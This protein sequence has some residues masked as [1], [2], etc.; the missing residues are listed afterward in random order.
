MSRFC[1]EVEPRYNEGPT[2]DRPS[3][4]DA[5]AAASSVAKSRKEKDRRKAVFCSGVGF[6]MR[7]SLRVVNIR[8]RSR[9]WIRVLVRCWRYL[10][11][12][13]V[14]QKWPPVQGGPAQSYVP[15]HATKLIN[16]IDVELKPH[17]HNPLHLS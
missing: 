13:R 14:S 9:C 8:I 2:H 11:M 4:K 1:H 5:V 16:Q 6:E 3:A 10:W 7:A 15:I 12:K 17:L